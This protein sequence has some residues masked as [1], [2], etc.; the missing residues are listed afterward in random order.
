[1][2]V[3]PNADIYAAARVG[4]YFPGVNPTL[5]GQ[6]VSLE[7]WFL[8][9]M[10]GVPDWNAARGNANTCG[11]TLV[12]QGLAVEV[13]YDQRRRGDVVCLEY[14][15]YGHVYI[16]LS[17]GRVFEENVNWS[18]VAHK[19]V[20]GDTVYAARIGSDQEAWRIAPGKNP[21]VYRLNGYSEGGGGGGDEGMIGNTDNEYARW[22]QLG[23][24][25]RG[26]VLGRDE[27]VAAA[28]GRTWL[29]A[30]E[31]LS[32]GAEAAEAQ[33]AQELG[34]LARRDNWQQQIYDRTNERDAANKALDDAHQT[35][36][37]LQ[38]QI[39]D[40]GS[41]PTQ[42]QLDDLNKKM[43]EATAAAQKARDDLSKLNQQ[44][45]ADTEVGNSFV[46]WLGGV[47]SKLQSK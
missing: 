23:V 11:R 38:K 43:A 9:E 45:A 29:Q 42:A 21:H 22:R 2:A 19:V 36:A 12:N 8:G 4:I 20:D 13:P 25:V 40:L 14:G 39:A 33:S 47:L 28:V 10:A 24:Q 32:D 34:Q 6:C 18:G 26:R 7:K 41:R 31:I 16:Q 5:D 46:R 1:M 30:I 3:A 15:T 37:D 27:F 44:T 35:I 17:G